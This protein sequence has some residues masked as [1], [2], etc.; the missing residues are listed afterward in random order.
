ME[1]LLNQHRISIKIDKILY[2]KREDAFRIM[3]IV[4]AWRRVGNSAI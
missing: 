4:C 2:V 3:R 1:K